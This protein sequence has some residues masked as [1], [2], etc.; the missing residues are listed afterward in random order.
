MVDSILFFDKAA[1]VHYAQTR[2]NGQS[3]HYG[4]TNEAFGNFLQDLGTIRVNFAAPFPEIITVWNAIISEYCHA[5]QVTRSPKFP[6][7][8]IDKYRRVLAA[9]ID[10]IKDPQRQEQMRALLSARGWKAGETPAPPLPPPPGVDAFSPQP[11]EFQRPEEAM[12]YALKHP[13]ERSAASDHET[14]IG[15]VR[16]P[17]NVEM[18]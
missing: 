16:L 13:R 1:L 12:Q 8:E 2:S 10:Q 14:L 3:A 17:L 9:G 18:E 5:R 7:V 4:I 6:Q 11:I 15:G